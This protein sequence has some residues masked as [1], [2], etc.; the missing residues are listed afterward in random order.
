M[1]EFISWRA[2]NDFSLW[3][4][5]DM[6]AIKIPALKPFTGPKISYSN[7]R[8]MN[9]AAAVLHAAQGIV[10]LLL[11][12]PKRGIEA[13]TTN[14][15]AVDKMASDAAGHPVLATATHHLFDLKL[16][17]LVAAFFFM[18]AA[19]HYF[20]ANHYQKRYEKD[21]RQG[22]NRARWVEYAFSASTMMVGI[23]L[24]S[25][26]FDFSSLL[27]LF[28]LIAVMSL[29][30]WV[31]EAHNRTAV[32]TNWLS[33]KV[34]VLAELVAWLVIVVYLMGAVIYGNGI[35]TFVYFIYGSL[36][37]LFSSFAANMYL[38]YKKI[39]HWKNYLYGERVYIILSLVAK[40]AL[41][42][43]IFA[44]TLRP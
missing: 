31:M 35:P 4:D 26:I 24:L 10:V 36:F 38:Q 20:V 29:M 18:S 27:M 11:A 32:K 8:K 30:G 33:F 1:T 19:A 43:Q 3:Y 15:L 23:A 37:I 6:I 12:D 22:M 13:I 16:A 42:W 41:A 21:L 14:Y 34:G 5:L 2:K 40:S 28:G 39:G 25:G 7:L 9:L 44:G 17:Y